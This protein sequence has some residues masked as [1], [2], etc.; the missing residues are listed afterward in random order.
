MWQFWSIFEDLNVGGGDLVHYVSTNSLDTLTCKA[1][2]LIQ[3]LPADRYNA[4]LRD[5]EKNSSAKLIVQIG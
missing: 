5:T 2:A 4:V 3:R 1:R